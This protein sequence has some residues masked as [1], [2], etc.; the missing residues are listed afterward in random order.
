MVADPRCLRVPKIKFPQ[1][2]N[3]GVAIATY[4]IVCASIYALLA[5]GFYTLMQPKRLPNVGL[6]AYKPA[7]G[8]VITYP[9]GAL[10]DVTLAKAP[11]ATLDLLADQP[12]YNVLEGVA[13]TSIQGAETTNLAAMAAAPPAKR[14]S[15]AAQRAPRKPAAIQMGVHN[16]PQPS[17]GLATAYAGY[18]A[19]Q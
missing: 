2:E 18:A 8:T 17:A 13:A 15:P 1:T 4:M 19:V 5:F 11:S 3:T 14:K 7:P 16:R 12:R 10:S 9:A 6:L